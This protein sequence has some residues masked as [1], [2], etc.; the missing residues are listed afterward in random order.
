MDRYE[1]LQIAKDFDDNYLINENEDSF[2]RKNIKE[3]ALKNKQTIKEYLSCDDTMPLQWYSQLDYSKIKQLTLLDNDSNPFYELYDYKPEALKYFFKVLNETNLLLKYY[4]IYKIDRL[5]SNEEQVSLATKYEEVIK[6]LKILKYK[7]DII[8]K[9]EARRKQLT[10]NN[11]IYLTKDRI[12]QNFLSKMHFVYDIQTDTE[13]FHTRQPVVKTVNKIICKYFDE[14][15]TFTRK[16]DILKL[17][18]FHYTFE[19]QK[20]IIVHHR[21]S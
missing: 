2:I 6:D 11:F 4:E 9:L 12:F 15:N 5:R 17:K 13:S 14:D 1:F 10:K 8:D 18:P 21:M 7:T 19:T 16:T 3:K 20:E